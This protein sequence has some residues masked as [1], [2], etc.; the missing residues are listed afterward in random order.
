MTEKIV[1]RSSEDDVS[2]MALWGPIVLNPPHV[3]IT[4]GGQFP[5]GSLGDYL[6]VSR[7]QLRTAFRAAHVQAGE[8]P[9]NSVTVSNLMSAPTTSTIVIDT[10]Y[11]SAL[12]GDIATYSEGLAAYSKLKLKRVP[13]KDEGLYFDPDDFVER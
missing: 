13:A 11:G 1:R 6:L 3:A 8:Q 5:Q 4:I 9:S 7:E 12:M 2:V 10:W